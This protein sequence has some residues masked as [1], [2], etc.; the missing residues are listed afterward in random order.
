MGL[1]IGLAC[2]KCEVGWWCGKSLA[3]LVGDEARRAL[4][5]AMNW[6]VDKDLRQEMEKMLRAAE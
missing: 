2:E 6:Q 1:A 5:R 3:Y 4:K